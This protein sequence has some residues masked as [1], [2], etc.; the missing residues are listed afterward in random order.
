MPLLL[1][2]S[3]HSP[4]SCPGHNEKTSN[5]AKVFFA[6]HD[7]FYWFSL[8]FGNMLATKLVFLFFLFSCLMK[9]LIFLGFSFVLRS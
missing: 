7:V 6:K 3:K 8:G 9:L 4:E 5:A 2:I 1:R